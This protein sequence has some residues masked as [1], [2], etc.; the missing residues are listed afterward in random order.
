MELKQLQYFVVSV[1][2]GSFHAAAK[3]LLTTQPNVSKTVK[4]LEDELGMTLLKRHRH[5]VSITPEGEP[6]YR[7]AISVLK[8]MQV[9]RDIKE[10]QNTEKLYICST[11]NHCLSSS[12]ASFHRDFSDQP[13]RMDYWE[14]SDEDV[15]VRMHRRESEVGFVYISNRNISAFR[16]HVKIKGLE[17]HEI[18]KAPLYLFVGKKNSYYSRESIDEKAICKM[19]FIQHYEEQYS[20]YN[21]LGH[22]REDGFYN[23]ENT[24]MASTNSGYFLMQLLSNTEYCTID[25]SYLRNELH[26][27]GIRAIP[28]SSCEN[29]IIFGYLKRLKN[30]LSPIAQRFIDYLKAECKKQKEEEEFE[31]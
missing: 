2:M 7:H 27:D 25:S 6:I 31:S 26:Y 19:H 16:S 5:G 10:D 20:L 22:L 13:I 23:G 14:G 17:F 1:D 9:I 30:P 12:L 29:S 4:S 28:I 11:P 18:T 8:N 21:H 15:I 3:A 24:K